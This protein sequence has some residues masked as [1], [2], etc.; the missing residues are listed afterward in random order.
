MNA[1]NRLNIILFILFPPIT[2]FYSLKNPHLLTFSPLIPV[3]TGGEGG[4]VT[5]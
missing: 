2:S 4:E 5:V 3:H 1:K